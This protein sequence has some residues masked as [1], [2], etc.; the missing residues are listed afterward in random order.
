MLKHFFTA[1][2]KKREKYVAA[3]SQVQTLRR[4]LE[5]LQ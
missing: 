2:R 5:E 1:A 3:P 4:T